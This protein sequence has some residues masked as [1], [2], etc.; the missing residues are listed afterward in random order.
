MH[1]SSGDSDITDID[2]AALGIMFLGLGRSQTDRQCQYQHRPITLPPDMDGRGEII[3]LLS[4]V[5]SFQ[6]LPM[7]DILWEYL[8]SA[9]RAP[10]SS[11]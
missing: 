1:S 9:K 10:P 2:G 7:R 3:T 6:L 4:V 5:L 11:D 8:I